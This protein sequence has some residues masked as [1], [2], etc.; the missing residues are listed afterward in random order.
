MT[1]LKA[2]RDRYDIQYPLQQWGWAREKCEQVIHDSGLP[3]PVKSACFMCPASKKAEIEALPGDLYQLS[4]DL[5]TIYQQGKHWRGEEA[6][7]VGLGRKF[8][9]SEVINNEPP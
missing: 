8:S 4:V 2:D 9:W 6:S 3:V 1:N 5:E 7:T